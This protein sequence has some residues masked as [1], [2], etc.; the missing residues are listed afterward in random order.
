VRRLNAHVAAFQEIDSA[1]LQAIG[2]AL[3]NEWNVCLPG[4]FVSK[5]P[6]EKVYSYTGSRNSPARAA[7]LK[8]NDKLSIKFAN[9]HFYAD[10]RATKMLLSGVSRDEVARVVETSQQ[11]SGIYPALQDLLLANA[12]DPELPIIFGGD[13]N[14]PS[15][16]DHTQSVSADK[17]YEAQRHGKVTFPMRWPISH[18]LLN[19]GFVDTFRQLH[20]NPLAEPGFTWP[21]APDSKGLHDRID[22]IYVRD[23]SSGGVQY[24]FRVLSSSIVGPESTDTAAF[25][26]DQSMLDD[27]F[28]SSFLETRATYAA[29]SDT[30]NAR[31]WNDYVQPEIVDSLPAGAQHAAGP[32]APVNREQTTVEAPKP[33]KKD[34]AVKSPAPAA[35]AP[36]ATAAATTTPAPSA[37]LSLTQI[38]RPWSE[39]NLFNLKNVLSKL[40]AREPT[41]EEVE[42]FNRLWVSDH[43]GVFSSVA[44]SS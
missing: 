28:A 44:I 32:S 26:E 41:S 22:Y 20:P 5:F 36:A 9:S 6:V 23:G 33:L 12:N 10:P 14:Q 21:A 25:Q 16:L 30:A 24:R 29:T 40:L 17:N 19:A 37:G 3:G 13:F 1:T 11:Q 15:E 31:D 38:F 4:D 39:L 7:R 34:I 27:R 43:F 18:E 8:I 2:A 42:R 35:A